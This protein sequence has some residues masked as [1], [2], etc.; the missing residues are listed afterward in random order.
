[1]IT[2]CWASFPP[3]SARRAVL[4]AWWQSRKVSV[5]GEEIGQ[6]DVLKLE[7]AIAPPRLPRQRKETQRHCGDGGSGG[8]DGRFGVNWT[9]SGQRTYHGQYQ[10]AGQVIDMSPIS[11]ETI[12]MEERSGGFEEVRFDEDCVREE[13]ERFI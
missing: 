3:L 7:R 4:G 12:A 5:G 13:E 2:S 9:T 8:V 10:P 11:D 1:M 6:R